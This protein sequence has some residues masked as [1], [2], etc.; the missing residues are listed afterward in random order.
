MSVNMLIVLSLKKKKREKKGEY[1]CVFIVH[2]NYGHS[3]S[4]ALS[5]LFGL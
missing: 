3:G 5:T 4:G 1:I 2:I